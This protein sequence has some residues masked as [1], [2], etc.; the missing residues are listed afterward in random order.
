MFGLTANPTF[1]EI[2]VETEFYGFGSLNSTY[3]C[4][5][6]DQSKYLT[7]IYLDKTVTGLYISWNG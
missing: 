4:M 3:K 7:P 5:E 6:C 2:Q 1:P